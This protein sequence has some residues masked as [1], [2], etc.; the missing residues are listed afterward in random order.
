[1]SMV[2]S[3]K[4]IYGVPCGGIGAGTIGR[5]FR[6]EFTRFQMIPGVYKYHTVWAD[7]FHVCVKAAGG[8][9]KVLFQ[10]VL[11]S[12][13]TKENR[14]ERKRLTKWDYNIRDDQ[15]E[16]QALYPQSWTTYA[17]PDLGLTL[18]CRQI[19]PFIPG[20]YKDSC[21]PASVFQWHVVNK[22]GRDLK[23]TLG[24]TFKNGWGSADDWKRMPWTEEI[25]QQDNLVGVQM[26]QTYKELGFTYGIAGNSSS[27]DVTFTR[28]N[29]F[30]PDSDGATF[31]N[32]LQVP[33]DTITIQDAEEAPSKNLA[34]ALRTDFKVR[35]GS[36]VDK[37]NFGLVWDMPKIKFGQ[38][39]TVWTRRYTR[40][41]EAG[42]KSSTSLAK[43]LLQYA[44][45]NHES[46][47][48]AIQ[49]WQEPVLTD[50]GLPDWFKSA[51]FNEMYF[52][53]DGGS[54]WLEMPTGEEEDDD[55]EEEER[56]KKKEADASSFLDPRKEFGRFCY[57]EGH[58]YRMYNTYD[59]HFYAS[60]ALMGLFPGLQLSLQTDFCHFTATTDTTTLN[61][62]YGGKKMVRN[63]I[64]SVPHDLGDPE[65]DPYLLVNAYR[66]VR[67]FQLRTH[68]GKRFQ[69]QLNLP[70]P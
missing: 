38:G 47:R 46:W 12:Q 59:V 70:N 20:N 1:M 44:L 35:A 8:S 52:L 53:A 24:F 11:A 9:D 58:E 56:K 68:S 15:L 21:L 39:Q 6:G 18:T 54:Q 48:E 62:L 69:G 13:R 49:A 27:K 25:V 2:I 32:E 61:E 7:A 40:F 37:I 36:T 55:D 3:G 66:Y 4:R 19:S 14:R 30:N 10:S 42:G 65:E 51:L 64:H 33:A 50:P 5:G 41:F 16:Y 29:D 60:F 43:Q 28:M 22:S 31:W 63:A 17:I 67:A 26:H 45:S 57:L 34:M 23:V